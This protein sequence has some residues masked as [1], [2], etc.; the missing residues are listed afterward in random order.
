MSALDGFHLSGRSR[1]VVAAG[2]SVAAE[3]LRIRGRTPEGIER[4]REQNRERLRKL[5]AERPEWTRAKNARWVAAN[6]EK[7]AAHKAVERA[8]RKGILVRQPCEVCGAA[9]R[10]HAHH[11]NYAEPLAV[12]W[13]CALHHKDAHRMAAL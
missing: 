10:V 9:S 1:D 7:V 2:R 11:E 13:L 12:R 5:R 8:L 6:P 4:R 3:P